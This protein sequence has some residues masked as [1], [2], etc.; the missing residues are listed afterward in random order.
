MNSFPASQ[1]VLAEVARRVRVAS[2]LDFV[3]VRAALRLLAAALF[4]SA[5]P[6]IH[7]AETGLA[8]I[9]GKVVD[10]SNGLVLR[11]AAI[12]VA[13]TNLTT[14][15][16]LQGSFVLNNVPAGQ[17]TLHVTYLGTPDFSEN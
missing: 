7:A 14:V 15:S 2:R 6:F 17:R 10:G 3:S 12:S 9:T 1:T 8:K 5:L 4:A 16:D 11:G 13:G